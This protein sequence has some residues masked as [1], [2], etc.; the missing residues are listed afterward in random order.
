LNLLAN[1]TFSK[2]IDDVPAGQEIGVT[3]GIQNYYDR[4]S[5]KSLSG[6]DVRNRFAFSSVYE[7]PWGK[8]RK[9]LSSGPLG[10]A[11]GG[12]NIGAIMTLQQGSPF[13]LTTQVNTINAFSG[14]QRVN[15]LRDPN[16]PA[17]ER[18][19]QR[20]FDTTAVVAPPQFTFGNANR[21]ILTGPGLANVNL[22]LLKNFAFRETWNLQFRLEAFNALNRANFEEPG[23]ALGSPN[24][25]VITA[26]QAARSMQ[27]GLKL[28]F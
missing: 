13:G 15:V 5:E 25:G 10:V 21:S 20:Y 6:N 16:L 19:V 12:W 9:Y 24:F 26:A 22:S 17:S 8:R 14:G 23:T 4:R 11:L 28:T 7:L 3:P 18:T 2:F 27:I 1:Y